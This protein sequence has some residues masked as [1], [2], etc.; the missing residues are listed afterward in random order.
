MSN[1][2]RGRS[3]E[4]E[5]MRRLKKE[6]YYCFRMAGSH[7]PFDVL[8]FLR[9]NQLEFPVIRAVQVKY[10]KDGSFKKEIKFL[11][12]FKMPAMVQKELWIY[13]PRRK[14]PEIIVVKNEQ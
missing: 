12:E 11:K 14:K 6:K 5:T 13:R 10:C 1:Y 8:A 3:K 7:S 9:A 4:Y 2:T